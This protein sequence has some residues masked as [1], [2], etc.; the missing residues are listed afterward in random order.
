VKIVVDAEFGGD[1]EFDGG[2]WMGDCGYQGG[3]EAGVLGA[4]GINKNSSAFKR[5]DYAIL[6]L[7]DVLSRRRAGVDEGLDFR[8]VCVSG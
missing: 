5:L 8:G 3:F 4:D 1:V 6:I 2:G 7:D